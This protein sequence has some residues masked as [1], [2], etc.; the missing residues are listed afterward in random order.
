MSSE[1]EANSNQTYFNLVFLGV[2]LLCLSCLSWVSWPLCLSCLLLSYVGCCCCVLLLRVL[3][4]C[5][6]IVRFVPCSLRDRQRR[7]L[8]PRGLLESLRVHRIRSKQQAQQH[9]LRQINTDIDMYRQIKE[10]EAAVPFPRCL[11]QA[12]FTHRTRMC[13]LRIDLSLQ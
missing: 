10:R 5:C 8:I 1:S 7:R 3:V 13:G 2:I 6:L 9:R 11:P 4:G 12:S